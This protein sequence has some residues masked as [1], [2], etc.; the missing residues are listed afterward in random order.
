[1]VLFASRGPLAITPKILVRQITLRPGQLYGLNRTQRTTSR[2][3]ALDMFRFNNVSFSKVPEAGTQNPLDT[4]QTAAPAATDHYLDALVTASPSPRFAETTEFGGTY[5]AGL[6]GP[7]GNLRLKWRN[8]FHGAEVLELSGRVGFE[9]QYNRLGADSSSPV[10]AVYTIQ[11]GVTAALLVPKLLVPFGL[12]NFLRDYQP[13]TRFSLSY[14]YTSTPYYTRTNA[15]F[16]FDYL[17]QTSPYHQYVFTPIDAALVKTPFIR[18]DYRDLLEVYRI[19]G[20]P[21]YQS[22]RSIYEPSFS[23]TSIYNSNDITQTRNAQYLRLFVEVGGLTRKLYRTQE[24]FR[25]DREPA[26]QLEAYDFAKIAVDYRRYYKLSPLTYLAWRLNGGVAHALTPTP[27]AA[28][29]TVSTYT[30]PY[31]KY[32]FVGG[33][34]SVRAWQPRRLGTG[35]Y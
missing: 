12:G 34:N 14:T 5:V 33:S 23:F 10:D 18:Q 29:P 4:L 25:G 30:I 13:R 24:W 3:G 2:L 27:T 21:L 9:G 15:E 22:F 31:D 16:T 35:A 32:F 1:S 7:F 6:P 17:W 19:A 11:Y 28:D 26:D 20:S 8:P